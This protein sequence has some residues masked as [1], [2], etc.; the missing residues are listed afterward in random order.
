MNSFK[1]FLIDSIDNNS[2]PYDRGAADSYYRRGKRPHKIVAG[3]YIEDLT[4]EEMKEY[5]KGFEENEKDKIFKDYG[6][7]R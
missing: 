5:D 1:Q 3:K 2:S 7:D 4:P 6:V